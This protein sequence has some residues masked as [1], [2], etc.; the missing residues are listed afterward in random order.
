MANPVEMKKEE[1]PIN[2]IS[3]SLVG[4]GCLRTKKKC[5]EVLRKKFSKKKGSNT[6]IDAFLQNEHV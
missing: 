3:V 6:Q 4:F 2:P 5:I 1:F